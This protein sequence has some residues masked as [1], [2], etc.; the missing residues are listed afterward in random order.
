MV[1]YGRLMWGPYDIVIVFTPY[2]A[3]AN[4]LYNGCPDKLTAENQNDYQKCLDKWLAVTAEYLKALEVDVFR[5]PFGAEAANQIIGPELLKPIADRAEFSGDHFKKHTLMVGWPEAET[6]AEA[7][8]AEVMWVLNVR[9]ICIFGF[10][11]T[12]SLEDARTVV[13]ALRGKVGYYELG[14][15]DYRPCLLAEYK[16]RITRFGGMIQQEDSQARFA[17]VLRDDFIW[18][19]LCPNFYPTPTDWKD[20]IVALDGPH[21]L[22]R[23]LFFPAAAQVKFRFEGTQLSFPLTIGQADTYTLTLTFTDANL[24]DDVQV[25][26][27]SM[28]L[29]WMG[30]GFSGELLAGQHQISITSQTDAVFSLDLTFDLIAAG[31]ETQRYLSVI[32]G[33]SGWALYMAAAQG[34]GQ[35]LIPSD[36]AGRKVWVSEIAEHAAVPHSEADGRSGHR[37][38][39]ALAYASG[40]MLAASDPRVEVILGHTLYEI[41][42]NGMVSGVGRAP[43]LPWQAGDDG[44]SMID[45]QPRPKFWVHQQL[46]RHLKNGQQLQVELP[47]DCSVAFDPAFC[48]EAGS[49]GL[50]MGYSGRTRYPTPLLQCWGS[51]QSDKKSLLCINRAYDQSFTFPVQFEGASIT[52]AQMTLLTGQPSDHNE[53]EQAMIEPQFQMVSLAQVTFPPRSLIR[54]DVDTSISK[55]FLPVIYKGL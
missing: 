35:D 43:W 42:W 50:Q 25:M 17:A 20:E 8:Q 36:I 15:E 13:Q 22:Q 44:F 4:P 45:P 29:Q 54:L 2:A 32:E 53:G 28:P 24:P 48:Y 33:R 34:L 26:A 3:T 21:R 51:D 52:S 11:G 10:C 41:A 6:L 38:L 5:I 55:V 27:G 40:F 46:A 1:L 30:T 39:D 9:D 47:F 31:G 14:S 16:E 18:P 12:G 23:H 19:R 7:A 37:W 49:D